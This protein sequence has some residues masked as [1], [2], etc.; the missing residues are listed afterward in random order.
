M[1]QLAGVI[2]AASHERVPQSADG[3]QVLRPGGRVPS[4]PAV[5]GGED[6]VLA[7]ERPDP[8]TG[9]YPEAPISAVGLRTHEDYDGSVLFGPE[10]KG[11]TVR[12]RLIPKKGFR[13]SIGGYTL[14]PIGVVVN[15]PG[16]SY[17]RR[18]WNTVAHN[19]PFTGSPTRVVVV[20]DLPELS[21][22]KK[23]GWQIT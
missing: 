19:N 2:A 21:E 1:P 3:S 23:R 7:V 16:A 12:C 11:V 17:P 22:K 18:L 10:Y 4:R 15:K 5:I 6:Q 9:C 13:D 8:K 14:E 20:A